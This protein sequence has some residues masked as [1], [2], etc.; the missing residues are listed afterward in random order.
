[1]RLICRDLPY[2]LDDRWSKPKNLTL[3]FCC[4][5]SQRTFSL[6]KR[7]SAASARS[8]HLPRTVMSMLAPLKT[9]QTLKR[10][11]KWKNNNFVS[12]TFFLWIRWIGLQRRRLFLPPQHLPQR[13]SPVPSVSIKLSLS[14]VLLPK[15]KAKSKKKK[16]ETTFF[17]ENYTILST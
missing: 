16:T 14:K 5:Q 15:S 1:M 3:N 13:I 4:G 7:P 10:R 12:L 9:K 6:I 17:W 11:L 8:K 2:R